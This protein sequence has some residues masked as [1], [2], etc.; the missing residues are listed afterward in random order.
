MADPIVTRICDNLVTTLRGITKAAGYSR[1]V[2][3]V[4]KTAVG[5]DQPLRD[6]ITVAGVTERKTDADATAGRKVE[7]VVLLGCL[8]D[9]NDDVGLAIQELAADVEKILSIDFQRSNLAI[10]TK[11]VSVV[12]DISEDLKPL[13]DCVIELSIPYKHK[14]GDPRT[15]A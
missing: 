6:S 3:H 9:E 13:G 10:D 12:Y 2:R 15:V 4:S 14:W 1:D 11:V 7:L 8:V 5:P